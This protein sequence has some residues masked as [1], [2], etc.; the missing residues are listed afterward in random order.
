MK[1]FA[2]ALIA[3]LALGATQSAVAERAKPSQPTAP[4][5]KVEP[6]KAKPDLV[7]VQA[8]RG[9]D[10]PDGVGRIYIVYKNIGP[11]AAG[12]STGLATHDNNV[13]CGTYMAV[14]PLAPGAV[15]GHTIKYC[16]DVPT[17]TRIRV[18]ADVQ[19]KV[20]ESKENNNRRFFNW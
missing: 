17:G 5:L 14:P 13:G 9:P 11:V 1:T 15:S 16:K 20:D 8:V 19:K 12:K 7:V 4:T 3:A 10:Y 2:Y 6:H 18:I